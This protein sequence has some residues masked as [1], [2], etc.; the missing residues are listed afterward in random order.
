MTFTVGIILAGCEAIGWKLVKQEHIAKPAAPVPK[1]PGL[2]IAPLLAYFRYAAGLP[3]DA[4]NKESAQAESAFK[5]SQGVV[6]RVKLT[7]LLGLL[8]PTEKRDEARAQRLLEGYLNDDTATSSETLKD[9]AAF[10]R[11]VIIEQKGLRERNNV[12]ET[13]RRGLRERNSVLE[14]EQKGL[15]ERYNALEDKLREETAR[16]DN[17]QGKL[18]TLKAIESSILKRK[19]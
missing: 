12:L 11:G 2:E 5:A 4:L 16:A 15:K 6:E 9:Y 19:R 10:L 14:T 18:D 7:M 3:S 17:L 13:E 8:G 1:D